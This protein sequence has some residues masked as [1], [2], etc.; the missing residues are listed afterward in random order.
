MELL[1]GGHD[2]VVEFVFG[3]DPHFVN[4]LV[5]V[6]EE[7]YVDTTSEA[8]IETPDLNRDLEDIA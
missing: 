4:E 1:C 7:F 5:V 3:P 6:L 8:C 2:R